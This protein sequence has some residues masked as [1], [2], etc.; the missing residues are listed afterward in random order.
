MEEKL[1]QYK[2]IICQ[3]LEHRA[4]LPISNAPDLKRHLIVNADQT[5]F[6][7]LTVGWKG[8]RYQHSI[9]FHL[10]IRDGKIWVHKDNTDL[11]IADVLIER[12]IPRSLIVLGFLPSYL[13]E[14]SGFAA[15]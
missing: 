2:E 7:L 11:G 4:G 6:A 1:K 5:E 8:K 12:G 10:E 15:A 3:V 13:L 9:V 14:Q